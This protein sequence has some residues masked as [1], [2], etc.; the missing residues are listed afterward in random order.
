MAAAFKPETATLGL[1]LV[2]LGI[3]WTLS[4]TGQ[5][6]MLSTLRTWWP[7]TL[8]LWGGLE[9]VNTYAARRRS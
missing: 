5:L 4:N 1:S 9:L 7:L 8:V 2:A 6:Q 3:L